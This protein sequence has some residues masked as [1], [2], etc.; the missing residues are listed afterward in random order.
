MLVFH[1]FPFFVG[2]KADKKLWST[3][4]RSCSFRER[5]RDIKIHYCNEFKTIFHSL[6]FFLYTNI[7]DFHSEWLLVEVNW[8]KKIRI[9]LKFWSLF[10]RMRYKTSKH[11]EKNCVSDRSEFQTIYFWLFYF[12]SFNSFTIEN[13]R[14]NMLPL[15]SLL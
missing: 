12:E 1:V 10:Y 11:F 6:F 5:E 14:K 13:V 8:W 4:D 7:R 9:H 15:L 3:S 2:I